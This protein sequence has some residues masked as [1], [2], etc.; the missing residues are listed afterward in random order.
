MC[1]YSKRSGENKTAGEGTFRRKTSAKCVKSLSAAAQ[2]SG[3]GP[4]AAPPWPGGVDRLS[5]AVGVC[6]KNY[7]II[8]AKRKI[9]TYQIPCEGRM[10]K[11]YI[12]ST[13]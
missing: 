8:N 10:L 4:P 5:P 3:G 11:I 2:A 13:K 7:F 12:L 1:K 6:E 9:I